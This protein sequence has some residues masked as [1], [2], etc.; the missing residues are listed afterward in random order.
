M[1]VN[2]SSYKFS[3]A[4]LRRANGRAQAC[5]DLTVD[6]RSR[7]GGHVKLRMGSTGVTCPADG[8]FAW[9][10]DASGGDKNHRSLRQKIL[11]QSQLSV[12]C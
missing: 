3:G 10:R 7:V 12:L 11:D 9:S 1:E 6:M 4:T 8:V 2:Q 5:G